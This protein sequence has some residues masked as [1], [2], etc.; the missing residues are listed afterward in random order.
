MPVRKSPLPKTRYGVS[1]KHPVALALRALGV[2]SRDAR[3]IVGIVFDRIAEGLRHHDSVETPI[4]TFR[5]VKQPRRKQVRQAFGR[6]EWIYQRR[7]RVVLD[8]EE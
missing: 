5:L 7:F 8:T 4:G 6:F 1:E 3:R 2:S